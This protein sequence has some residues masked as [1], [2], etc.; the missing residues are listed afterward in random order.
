MPP[1]A[2]RKNLAFCLAVLANP[3]IAHAQECAQPVVTQPAMGIVTDKAPEIAWSAVP[4]AE[5]Y[6]VQI[7]IRVPEGALLGSLDTQVRRNKFRPPLPAH[8]GRV[9]VITKVTPYCRNTGFGPSSN[10]DVGGRFLLESRGDC[11]LAETPKVD[12]NKGKL[13]LSWSEAAGAQAYEIT[14]FDPAK[15]TPRESVQT[16][17]ARHELTT[18]PAETEMIGVRPVCNGKPGLY[19]LVAH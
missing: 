17:H 7:A 5:Y 6:R 11:R 16:I 13:L 1:Y 18:E 10:P 4:G 3:L 14:R 2:L 12:S 15:G 19:S 9:L 8:A